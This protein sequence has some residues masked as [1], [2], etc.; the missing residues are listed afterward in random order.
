M[1]SLQGM[2]YNIRHERVIANVG[3]IDI[4]LRRKCDPLTEKKKKKELMYYQTYS[5]GISNSVGGR[6]GLELVT[7]RDGRLKGVL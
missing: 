1:I 2:E 7:V 5:W 6:H 4:E 3:P